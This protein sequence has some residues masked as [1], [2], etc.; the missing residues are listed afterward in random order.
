MAELRWSQSVHPLGQQCSLYQILQDPA[1]DAVRQIH[2]GYLNIT[3]LNAAPSIFLRATT[4]HVCRPPTWAPAWRLSCH[5][6]TE[7]SSFTLQFQEYR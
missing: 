4:Q 5:I 2:S 1:P 7:I 6:Y 3:S